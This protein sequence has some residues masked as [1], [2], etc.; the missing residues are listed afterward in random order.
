MISLGFI[1]IL[2]EV[3]SA[4]RNLQLKRRPLAAICTWR[5]PQAFIEAPEA[6]VRAGPVIGAVL[7]KGRME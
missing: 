2:V 6:A 3:T 5:Q 1:T 7:E 4:C